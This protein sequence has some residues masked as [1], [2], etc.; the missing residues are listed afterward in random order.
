MGAR[1]ARHSLDLMQNA[2]Y[3]CREGTRLVYVAA[4][5]RSQTQSKE[6][7]IVPRFLHSQLCASVS[8]CK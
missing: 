7:L 6:E 4:S 2:M 1:R 8:G 5:G 3:V